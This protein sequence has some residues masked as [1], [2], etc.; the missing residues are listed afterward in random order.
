MPADVRRAAHANSSHHSQSDIAF[1]HDLGQPFT[2]HPPNER[3]L[4]IAEADQVLTSQ[5]CQVPTFRDVGS[6]SQKAVWT[7]LCSELG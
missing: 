4:M 3:R 1:S 6:I 5:E 2:F 7:A